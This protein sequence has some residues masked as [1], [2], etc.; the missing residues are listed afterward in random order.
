[1]FRHRVVK[2]RVLGIRTGQCAPSALQGTLLLCSGL[3]L[4]FARVL[5]RDSYTCTCDES[6]MDWG[7]SGSAVQRRPFS[8]VQSKACRAAEVL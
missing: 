5:A 7:R 8:G 1:M 6:A 3:S 2:Q 4:A